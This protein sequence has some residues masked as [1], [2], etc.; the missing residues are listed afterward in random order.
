MTRYNKDFT[1]IVPEGD[2]WLIL[3]LYG[4]EKSEERGVLRRDYAMGEGEEG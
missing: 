1:P 4:K 3:S 2:F